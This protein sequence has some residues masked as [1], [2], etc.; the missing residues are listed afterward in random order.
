MTPQ[1]KQV[2]WQTWEKVV[3]IADTA[4]DLF[5]SRL[6]EIDPDVKGLFEKSDMAAQ[7]TKLIQ[8]LASAISCLDSPETLKPL[9]VD[10]GQKHAGFGVVKRHY[11]IVGSALLWTLEQGLGEDWTSEA[12]DGWTAAY[13]FISETMQSSVNSTPETGSVFGGKAA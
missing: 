4:A 10:L 6:F 8:T 3:P 2:V 5:Y 11:E 9:L 1:Q 7:K 13:A 12:A